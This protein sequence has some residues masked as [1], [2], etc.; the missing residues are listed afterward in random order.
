VREN[1]AYGNLGASERA[2]ERAA[3]LANA[4]DF[5]QHLPDGYD[6]ILGERGSTL[7]GG[8][9]QRIAIARAAIRQAPIIILDEPTTGL[10]NASERAVTE[11]LQRLTTGK[12]TFTISHN[13]QSVENADLILY[14]ENGRIVEQGTHRELLDIGGRYTLLYRE[15]GSK[16]EQFATIS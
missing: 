13:L 2:I 7:S 5:I 3:E 16:P 14:L 6:T 12:T 9:R 15:Y 4:H 10:D 8:Q 1:I 11:A